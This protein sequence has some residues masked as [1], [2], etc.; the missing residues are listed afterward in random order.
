MHSAIFDDVA[1]HFVLPLPFHPVVSCERVVSVV[2]C[3]RAVCNVAESAG[4]DGSVSC[5]EEVETI[6][7]FSICS[8]SSSSSG[9]RGGGMNDGQARERG[10]TL[11]FS[12]PWLATRPSCPTADAALRGIAAVRSCVGAPRTD[13][14]LTRRWKEKASR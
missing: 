9:E 4:R 2:S 14:R 8:S 1:V 13:R 6:P 3:E 12:Q 11:R 7:P 5:R 10:M